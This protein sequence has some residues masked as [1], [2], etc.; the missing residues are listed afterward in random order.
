MAVLSKG[1]SIDYNDINYEPT[2]IEEVF[3][4]TNLQCATNIAKSLV[5]EE[6]QI[7]VL[8]SL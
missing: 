1:M 4:D 7:L 6:K 5:R 3:C 2:I 8:E